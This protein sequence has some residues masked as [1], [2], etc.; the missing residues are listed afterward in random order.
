MNSPVFC[1]HC[2]TVSQGGIIF[3]PG[4]EPVILESSDESPDPYQCPVCKKVVPG[5]ARQESEDL[6]ATLVEM[7]KSN[8]E[9][10]DEVK[11]IAESLLKSGASD[12]QM[13]EAISSRMPHAIRKFRSHI[14]SEKTSGFISLVVV[15]AHLAVAT[16]DLVLVLTERAAK[17]QQTS[18]LPPRQPSSTPSRSR[19]KGELFDDFSKRNLEKWVLIYTGNPRGKNPVESRQVFVEDGKLHLYVGAAAVDAELGPNLFRRGEIKK[20]SV[21]MAL[22]AMGG[23]GNG[24]AF[25]V[26]SR[27][28]PR[29]FEYRQNLQDCLWIGPNARNQPVVGHFTKRRYY[30]SN[31]GHFTHPI[32]IG[33]EYLVEAIKLMK[34]CSSL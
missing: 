15:A 25:F 31:K 33:S 6:T 29:H 16:T 10:F 8:R 13:D 1:P 22:V 17:D 11:N 24:A 23:H 30:D 26:V 21:K 27:E 4:A 3:P 34:V 18:T 14:P 19:A 20:I 32:E 7:S 12:Q 28:N 2:A 9:L 5:A